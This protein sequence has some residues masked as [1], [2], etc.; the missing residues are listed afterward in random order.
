MA[1]HEGPVE[2]RGRQPATQKKGGAARK[3]RPKRPYRKL[4]HAKI[5][6]NIKHHSGKKLLLQRKTDLIATR[7]Q[8]LEAKIGFHTT[9]LDKYAEELTFRAEDAADPVTEAPAEPA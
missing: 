2:R 4:L 7:L 5:E 6:A 1:I 8:S 3:R 9:K